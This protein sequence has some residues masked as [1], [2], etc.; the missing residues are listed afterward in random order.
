[1]EENTTIPASYADVHNSIVK[2]IEAAR[3]TAARNVNALM[4]A[5][6]WEIGRYIVEFEQKGEERAFYG[7]ELIKGLS[8][9]LTARF[10]RGFSQRNLEQMRLFYQ[11]WPFPQTL[12]AES[13]AYPSG[14][15]SLS[16]SGTTDLMAL[17]SRFPL[18]WSAYVRLLSVKNSAGRNF[19]ETE[20]VHCGW[21][22]RQLDRQIN[23]QL[24]E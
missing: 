8:I 23:S 7:A 24:Y 16:F 3:Y 20:A 2:L 5:S 11:C 13:S 4:T 1:M 19:Y 12:S 22:V 9:D 21:S 10:G 14:S 15:E 6:Y 18:P 17:G